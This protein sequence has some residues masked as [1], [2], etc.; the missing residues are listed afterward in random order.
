[1]PSP[2]RGGTQNETVGHPGRKDDPL[3][4]SRK[5]LTKGHERLDDTGEAK[6]ISL[7]EAGDPRGYLTAARTSFRCDRR[8]IVPL[9]EFG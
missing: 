9:G 8:D 7:L 4:R 6:L 5:L 3:Y 1:M 2:N